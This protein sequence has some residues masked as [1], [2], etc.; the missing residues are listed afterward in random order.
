MLMCVVLE[1]QAI[2]LK[3]E[4]GAF[5]QTLTDNEETIVSELNAV[6][7]NQVDISGYYDPCDDKAAAAMRPS[8]TF[9][10]AIAS[11]S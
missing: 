2:F 4:F 1:F 11:L 9:N 10:E 8:V 7:G 3:A 5:A 6:Q